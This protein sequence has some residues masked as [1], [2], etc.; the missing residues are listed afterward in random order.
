MS[1]DFES[2]WRLLRP[3]ASPPKATD[4]LSALDALEGVVTDLA[5]DYDAERPVDRSRVEGPRQAAASAY[6][7]WITAAGLPGPAGRHSFQRIPGGDAQLAEV[8]RWLCWTAFPRE[9]RDLLAA[10]R[11]DPIE[12]PPPSF[13]P[14][15][16]AFP[17]STWSAADGLEVSDEWLVEPAAALSAYEGPAS[18]DASWLKEQIRLRRID[19][20]GELPG[21]LVVL[22]LHHCGKFEAYEAR[23]VATAQRLTGSPVSPA[24]AAID[25]ALAA[26][27]RSAGSRG[28]ALAVDRGLP[29]AARIDGTHGGAPGRRRVSRVRPDRNER[30]TP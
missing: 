15:R 4:M 26:Q 2:Y 24:I 20:H 11:G 17:R 1:E 23:I 6:G 21:I 16:I 28:R 5:G 10:A 18:L 9:L 3:P 30:G 14:H 19:I 22:G 13:Y 7:R 27:A 29:S 8:A 25:E 12:A